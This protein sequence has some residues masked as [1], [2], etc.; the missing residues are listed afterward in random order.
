MAIKIYNI[1]DLDSKITELLEMTRK[2]KKV[3]ELMQYKI[4]ARE[5]EEVEES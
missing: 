4:K 2:N 1:L 3:L 5:F